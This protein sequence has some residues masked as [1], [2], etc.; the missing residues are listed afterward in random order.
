MSKDVNNLEVF[1]VLMKDK[2][3]GLDLMKEELTTNEEDIKE[4]SKSKEDELLSEKFDVQEEKVDELHPNIHQRS[5][6][7]TIES[8]IDKEYE[9]DSR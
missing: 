6:V 7:T 4:G 2:S 8:I 9:E 5:N 1:K 3:F